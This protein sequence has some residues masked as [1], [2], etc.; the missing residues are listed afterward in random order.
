[1]GVE[2]GVVNLRERDPI[3]NYWLAELLVS[4][5]DDMSRVQ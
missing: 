4:V 5:S 2:R 1:M 3:R